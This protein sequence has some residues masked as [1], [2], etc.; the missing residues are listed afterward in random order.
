VPVA[1][2][3]HAGLSH[4]PISALW[5]WVQTL[6]GHS[7]TDLLLP[8]TALVLSPHHDDETIGCGLLM[9]EKVRRGTQVAVAV[10]TDG[11][12]GW[13]SPSPRPAPDHIA[14]IRRREWHC[15]L[16]VL[17]V[18]R[19][20]RFELGLPDGELSDQ[21]SELATRIADLFR[22]VRPSQV[23]VTKSADPHS[24]HR[25]LARAAL[26]AVAQVYEGSSAGPV[27]PRPEVFSYRVYPA[28]GLWSDGRPSGASTGAAIV[29]FVHSVLGV[30]ARRPLVFRASESRP[31]K[32]SAI[33]SYESQSTLLSGEL[34]Y[35]WA[36]GVELYWRVEGH[37][38]EEARGSIERSN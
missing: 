2:L 16:D 38:P 20:D 4:P 14:E 5:G 9:A 36:S 21:E 7:A 37:R 27:G 28:E 12:H 30:T 33:S 18:P 34:R 26:H 8:G 22:I 24:D 1:L 35:V 32:A 29:R 6:A 31:T 11:R 10:A 3:R 15:A 25:A 19:A 13:H 23:F 17:T